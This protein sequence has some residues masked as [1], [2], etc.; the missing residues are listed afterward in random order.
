MR[1]DVRH[2]GGLVRQYETAGSWSLTACGCSS[3]CFGGGAAPP[4]AILLPPVSSR[5]QES[6]PFTFHWFTPLRCYYFTQ[7]QINKQS[8]TKAA[9]ETSRPGHAGEEED[10]RFLAWGGG[11][12]PSPQRRKQQQEAVKKRRECRG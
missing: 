10:G 4:P 6:Q 3:S 1:E 11:Q 7:E 12:D 2:G 8:K 5:P 9:K